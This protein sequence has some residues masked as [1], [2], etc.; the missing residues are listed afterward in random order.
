[1][2]GILSNG[3]IEV[4]APTKEEITNM[5]STIQYQK[6]HKSLSDIV[7][8]IFNDMS[9]QNQFRDEL[10]DIT[11]KLVGKKFDYDS[12]YSIIEFNYSKIKEK[13]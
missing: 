7:H 11:R 1:M 2:N 8:Q 5:R 9:V 13:E 6:E 12:V 4:P 10:Y 3:Y